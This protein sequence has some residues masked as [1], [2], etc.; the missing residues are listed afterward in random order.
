MRMMRDE[1][2]DVR[3]RMTLRKKRMGLR[4]TV[5]YLGNYVR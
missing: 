5:S 1:N 2:D 3:M 4:A